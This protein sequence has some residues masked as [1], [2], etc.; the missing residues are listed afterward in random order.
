MEP[1]EFSDCESKY[2][3]EAEK[4]DMVGKEFFSKLL[5]ARVMLFTDTGDL[6]LHSFGCEYCVYNDICANLPIEVLLYDGCTCSINS[7]SYY[8]LIEQVYPVEELHKI[9]FEINS[10]IENAQEKLNLMELMI[11]VEYMEYLKKNKR[12]N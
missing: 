12:E 3:Y 9:L 1:E 8:K 5:G 11:E 10:Y 4:N 6:M 2:D 7:F